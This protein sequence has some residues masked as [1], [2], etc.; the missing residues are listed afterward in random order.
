MAIGPMDLVIV[1][2]GSECGVGELGTVRDMGKV[3]RIR[4]GDLN[5]S[6]RIIATVISSTISTGLLAALYP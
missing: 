2:E 4:L 5:A 6:G 3:G 1:V